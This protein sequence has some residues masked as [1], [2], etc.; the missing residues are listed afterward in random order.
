[1]GL[2]VEF[3]R[4]EINSIPDAIAEQGLFWGFFSDKGAK[5]S[6]D[7]TNSSL[8]QRFPCWL[9][10]PWKRELNVNLS[11][12]FTDDEYYGDNTTESIKV[13]GV[14]RIHCSSG[15]PGGTAFR[16]PNLR[17]LFLGGSTGFLNVGD[18]C[19]VPETA[20]DNLTGEYN[21]ANDKRDQLILDNCRA[22]GVDPTLANNGG[23]NT[24][25]VEVQQG[26]SLERIPRNPIPGTIG[27]SYEQDFSN[28]FDLSFGMTFSEIEITNT[29][30][31]PH[32]L[33]HWRLL[34]R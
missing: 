7:V 16:A 17:E 3:R 15:E 22:T 31:D 10:C 25:S 2:G 30:I 23:F 21:P 27:F 20:I 4:D 19:Y 13:G 6:R 14:R 8:K 34:Y 1:M 33:Y 28:K 26:G 18:P 29:V 9:I 12:R 24:Y 11:A 32:R 5:G